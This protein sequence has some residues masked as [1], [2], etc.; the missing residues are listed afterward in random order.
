MVIHTRPEIVHPDFTGTATTDFAIAILAGLNWLT[1]CAKLSGV[2]PSKQSGTIR[3]FRR[4]ATLAHRWWLTE[5][6]GERSS[7]ML[8]NGEQPPNALFDMVRL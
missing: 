6:A 5:G 3:N 7:Q 1:H 4:I 2:D 8:A